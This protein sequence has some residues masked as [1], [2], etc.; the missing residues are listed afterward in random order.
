MSLLWLQ[1]IVDHEGLILNTGFSR[2]RLHWW[3]LESQEVGKGT[4]FKK[5]CPARAVTT[6][7]IS[8]VDYIRLDDCLVPMQ[9]TVN[10]GS[11]S[12]GNRAAIIRRYPAFSWANF[13]E[14]NRDR[15]C[16]CVCVCVCACVRT[17][18]RAC[19]RECVR[20]CVHRKRFLENLQS[21]HRRSWHSHCLRN[22]DASRVN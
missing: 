16:V 20:M 11:F 15:V 8:A 5:I 9:C 18:A 7:I 1:C 4:K 6:T 2:K 22:E 13:K 21:H 10:S 3:Q 12:R 14:D 17:C 19:V